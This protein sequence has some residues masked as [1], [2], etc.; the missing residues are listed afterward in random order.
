MRLIITFRAIDAHLVTAKRRLS[1]DFP[2]LSNIIVRAGARALRFAL[3]WSGL[4][5]RLEVFSA[6]TRVARASFTLIIKPKILVPFRSTLVSSA[7]NTSVSSVCWRPQFSWHAAQPEKRTQKFAWN[8][9]NQSNKKVIAQQF[10]YDLLLFPDWLLWFCGVWD[11][12]RHL[13]YSIGE[14][15]FT[16]CSNCPI[17]SIEC[18]KITQRVSFLS[19]E[20]YLFNARALKSPQKFRTPGC[21]SANFLGSW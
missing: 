14:L 9:G 8:V 10:L 12:K 7:E 19:I 20:S 11:L 18:Q 17:F 5:T 3:A 13:E 6:R 16:W 1:L 2:R 21:S 15:F 4:V